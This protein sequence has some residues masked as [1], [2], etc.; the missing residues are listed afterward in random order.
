MNATI[1]YDSHYQMHGTAIKRQ[2]QGS[3]LRIHRIIDFKSI[4]LDHSATLS[5]RKAVYSFKLNRFYYFGNIYLNLKVLLI[6]FKSLYIK[7]SLKL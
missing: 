1:Y 4:A 7:N 3:N 5:D 6:S 2:W